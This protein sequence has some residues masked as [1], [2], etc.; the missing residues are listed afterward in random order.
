MAKHQSASIRRF[1]HLSLV[2]LFL[3][4]TFGLGTSFADRIIVPIGKSATFK[5]TFPVKRVFVVRPG[6]IEAP[7][8]TDDEILLTG[9]SLQPEST[10]IILWDQDG[11]KV[12][13]DVETF[14]ENDLLAQK[15][16]TLAGEPGVVLQI[17]PD[18]VYIKGLVDTDEK[19]A[20]V[21]K[22]LATLITDRKFESLLQVRPAVT[23][24]QRIA[25]AIKIPTVQVTILSKKDLTPAT[26]SGKAPEAGTSGNNATDTQDNTLL[27]EGTVETQNDYIHMVEVAKGFFEPPK[28]RNLVTITHPAQVVFQAYVVEMTRETSKE[29]GIRWGSATSVGGELQQGLINFFESPSKITGLAPQSKYWNPL[30]MNNLNRF[31]IIDAQIRA[32]ETA[33][34]AKVL[35][36][37]KLIVY[38]NAKPT[39]LAGSGWLGEGLKTDLEAD[40][41]A[42]AEPGDDSGLAFFETGVSKKIISTYDSNGRPVFDTV[43]SNLRLT[44]RDLFVMGDE[45]KFSVYA[46]QEEPLDSVAGAGADKSTRSLMTTLK[47]RNGETIVL[48]GLINRRKSTAEERVPGLS[49][50]PYLGRMF[51]WKRDRVEETE[52]VVL[53]TPEIT[54]REKDALPVKKFESVPVPRRSD[55]LEKLHTIFQKIQ[56]SHFPEEAG[57]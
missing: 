30:E 28:I 6:I 39:K 51:R 19:K 20:R 49:R 16:A 15:F 40:S 46:L 56:S 26:D 5:T 36:N 12:I 21:E 34:K 57:R 2:G 14:Q 17:L 50:L 9:V 47:S 52:L 32:L 3:A 25:D 53:L 7:V 10:Q 54:G 43:N 29:L 38:A 33:N 27:L 4:L 44:I 41:I 13:H 1:F 31:E 18:I 23:V 55:R 24:Q 45:L 8:V 42:G 35:A 37:P 48:G 11:N 22:I